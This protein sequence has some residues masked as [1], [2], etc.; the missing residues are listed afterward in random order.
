MTDEFRRP[1]KI[2]MVVVV[3]AETDVPAGESL[4]DLEMKLEQVLPGNLQDLFDNE[5]GDSKVTVIVE[6][7]VDR[8]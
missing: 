7:I 3:E 5:P 8:A 4:V 1:I 6:E 2:T